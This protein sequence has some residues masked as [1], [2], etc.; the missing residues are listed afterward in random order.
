MAYQLSIEPRLDPP[1]APIEFCCCCGE[2]ASYANSVG[3]YCAGCV[4]FLAD[5][6]YSRMALEEKAEW[7]GFGVI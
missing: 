3:A 2:I 5:D 4:E 7:A 1:P 6:L